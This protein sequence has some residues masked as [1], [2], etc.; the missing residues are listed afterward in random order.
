[1]AGASTSAQARTLPRRG[2]KSVNID[3][4]FEEALRLSLSTQ[5]ALQSLNRY[6]RTVVIDILMLIGNMLF[7][8]N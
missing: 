7:R 4:T 6:N 8:R 3:L 5:S 2:V 1:M